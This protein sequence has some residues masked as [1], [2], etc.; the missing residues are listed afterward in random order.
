MVLG[1]M[2]QIGSGIATITLIIIVVGVNPR[3][4]H[5][6]HSN[7]HSINYIQLKSSRILGVGLKGLGLDVNGFLALGFLAEEESPTVL[8]GVLSHSLPS[9]RKEKQATNWSQYC[10]YADYCFWYY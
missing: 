3:P 9:N 4:K 6:F 8:R 5:S 1:G 10:S 7:V 2:S